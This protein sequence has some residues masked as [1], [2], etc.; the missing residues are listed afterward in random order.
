MDSDV[1]IHAELAVSKFHGNTNRKPKYDMELI[2]R[3][4]IEYEL[5]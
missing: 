3:E 1:S 2:V 5:N 4:F